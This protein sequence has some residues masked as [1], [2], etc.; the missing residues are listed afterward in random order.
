VEPQM[1]QQ[2]SFLKPRHFFVRLQPGDPSKALTALQFSW[3]RL[4]PDYPLN[5]HFIDENLNRFY[6]SE[7]R[8]GHIVGWAGGISVFLAMLGLLGLSALAAANRTKEIGIRKVLGASLSTIVGLLS[9]DLLQLV[10]LAFCVAAPLAGW[11]MSKWLQDYAYRIPIQWW[12]FVLTGIATVVVAF[13]TTSFQA[14][15]AG[16]ANPAKS[17]QTE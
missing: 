5:Y 9:K 7:S 15:K 17:L 12:V 1:F 11:F 10:L 6:E 14:M 16:M 4:A 2:F 3:K 8:W 13:V